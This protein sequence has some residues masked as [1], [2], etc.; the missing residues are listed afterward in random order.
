[1]PTAKKYFEQ[2]DFEYKVICHYDYQPAEKQT[3]DYPGCEA[4]VKIYLT[5][6]PNY[7]HCEVPVDVIERWEEEILVE[8]TQ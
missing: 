2:G 7:E 1:M 8:V 6:H 3:Q 4:E 5:T